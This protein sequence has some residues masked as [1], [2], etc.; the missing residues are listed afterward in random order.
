M[1]VAMRIDVDFLLLD[2][3]V[4][5]LKSINRGLKGRALEF[6]HRE[7]GDL[8]TR[9]NKRRAMTGRDP[10]GRFQ[11]PGLKPMTKLDRTSLGVPAGSPILVRTGGMVRSV[12]WDVRRD[13]G[14]GMTTTIKP[15]GRKNIAKGTAHQ[16][17]SATG[18]GGK[19]KLPVREWLGLAGRDITKTKKVFRDNIILLLENKSIATR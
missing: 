7:S 1:P 14:K 3:A 6:A 11:S 2:R 9:A 17:G 4:Q 5:R 10:R 18:P 12:D 13:P 19:T 15:H 8:V 16:F